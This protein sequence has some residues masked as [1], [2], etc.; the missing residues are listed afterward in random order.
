M[1]VVI[2]NVKFLLTYFYTSMKHGPMPMME[3]LVV[4]W[5]RILSLVQLLVVFG[6]VQYDLVL[7]VPFLRFCYS[8]EALW[9][10]CTA[11]YSWSR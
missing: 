11:D 7:I 3:R 4:G 1:V 6:T 8:Q 5:Q 10:G 9:K 2:Q